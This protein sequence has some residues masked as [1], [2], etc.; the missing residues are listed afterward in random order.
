[1]SE[2]AAHGTEVRSRRATLA[3]RIAAGEIDLADILEYQAPDD[4]E[5]VALGMPMHRLLEAVPGIAGATAAGILGELYARPLGTLPRGNRLELAHQ[6]R[7]R[8]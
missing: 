6:V 1:M 4:V 7:K 8:Q 2:L 3:R 5:E